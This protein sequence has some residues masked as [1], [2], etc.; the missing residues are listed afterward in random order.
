MDQTLEVLFASLP[1]I[2]FCVV[3]WA[4]VVL[5]RRILEGWIFNK[6]KQTRGK[7]LSKSLFYNE[8]A[9]PA[10]PIATSVILA[11]LFPQYPLFTVMEGPWGRVF[12]GIF[13]GLFCG[14]LYRFVKKYIV[15]K[16]GVTKDINDF[17]YS[18]SS[19]DTVQTI[20]VQPST[21]KTSATITTATTTTVVSPVS[22]PAVVEATI[23]NKETE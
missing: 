6:I 4:L 18:P 11:I 10:G 8:V 19:V 1:I 9:L 23:P 12:V 13:L 7:D 22:D 5:Q 3:V 20:T 16:L 15:A 2:V 17:D 14:L 21:E